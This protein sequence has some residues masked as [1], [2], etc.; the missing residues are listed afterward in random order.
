MVSGSVMAGRAPDALLGVIVFSPAGK[1][2]KSITSAPA[3]AF[4][5]IIA[6]RSDPAPVSAVVVTVNVA[7]SEVKLASS[8]AHRRNKRCLYMVRACGFCVRSL[9][10]RADFDRLDKVN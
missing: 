5:S 1:M 8:G 10:S 6:W 4:A 2:L 3:L 9:R 7:P